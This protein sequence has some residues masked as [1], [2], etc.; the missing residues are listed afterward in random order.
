GEPVKP[1]VVTVD[2]G[3]S[4]SLRIN[5]YLFQAGRAIQRQALLC[6]CLRAEDSYPNQNAASEADPERRPRIL[7]RASVEQV[8]PFFPL[9]LGVF[10]RHFCQKVSFNPSC[11]CRGLFEVLVTL[12][13]DAVSIPVAG[14]LKLAVFVRL[15]ASARNCRRDFSLGA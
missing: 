12:P 1:H 6:S 2:D 9:R 4:Y 11:N 3:Y 8:S 5:M 7:T 13:P 14:A 15:N 10:A